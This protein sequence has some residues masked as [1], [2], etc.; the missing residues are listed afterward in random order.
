MCL[1]Y[2]SKFCNGRV[3][4][5][6]I[7]GEDKSLPYELL[8]AEQQPIY[9]YDDYFTTKIHKFQQIYSRVRDHMKT[10]SESLKTQQHK[11]PKTLIVDIGD[12]VMAKIHVRLGG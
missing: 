11:K 4:A 5:N 1:K 9:N 8:N 7:F 6:V 2:T 3:T 12:V 10:Y